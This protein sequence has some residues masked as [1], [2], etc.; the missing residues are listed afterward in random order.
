[1][2]T[3][4]GK[5]QTMSE[6]LAPSK[7]YR[8]WLIIMAALLSLM[9]IGMAYEFN[10]PKADPVRMTT[11]LSSDTYSYLDI[12]LVSDWLLKVTGVSNYTISEAMD[13][14]GNW[15]LITLDDDAFATLSAQ[16][17]AYN[18]YYSENS[19]N[20]VLPSPVRLTGVTHLMDSDDVS[21]I[22]SIFD[23]TTA[24]QITEF[25][26]ANYFGTGENNQSDGV[27][28][29]V[30]GL[31]FF[32]MFFLILLINTSA[33][34]KNYRKSES[35]LYELG[36]LDE[37]EAEYSAPESFRYPKSK[38][39]LSKQFVFC[40][41]SGWIVPYEDIG[42]AYQRTQRSYGIPISKQI[43]AGLN[44]G[45]TVVLAAKGVN[46]AVLTDA[47]R[48]IYTANPNCLIGYSFDNIKLYK[49]RVKEYK[50]SHRK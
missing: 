6:F 29:Y 26:G 46:D 4:R 38:L 50:L 16:Q 17:D 41:V 22:A 13:P 40:G 24:A 5:Q 35:R 9:I 3:Q 14:D 12:S 25:Y 39:I 36:K 31:I 49:Q 48:A 33:V 10:K 43:V 7:S 37:A 19:Q 32:G 42:W 47:A 2:E 21:Q 34:R 1:M 18:V 44:N 15:F 23:N 20:F 27:Y 11:Q 30:L 8:V 28:G 45:K